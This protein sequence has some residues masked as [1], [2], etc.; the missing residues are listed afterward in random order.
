M[1]SGFGGRPPPLKIL[2]P[3]SRRGG[4][5]EAFDAKTLK[6]GSLDL[7]AKGMDISHHPLEVRMVDPAIAKWACCIRE[8]DLGRGPLFDETLFEA[9]LMEIVATFETEAGCRTQLLRPANVAKL[10]SLSC[11]FETRWTLALSEDAQARVS[12]LEFDL[13]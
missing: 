4:F 11:A 1:P 12:T 3:A 5:G 2:V 6:S 10:I 13:T 7:A 9:V 8:G